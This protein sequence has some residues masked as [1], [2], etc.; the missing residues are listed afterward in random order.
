VLWYWELDKDAVDAG[1]IVKSK[2]LVDELSFR[3]GLGEVDKF[4]IDACLEI[5]LAGTK[6]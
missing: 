6:G 2:D 3:A 4:T 5:F 1:V